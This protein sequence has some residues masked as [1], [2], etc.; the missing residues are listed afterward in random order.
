MFG[1]GLVLPFPLP[2]HG[3]L[4]KPLQEDIRWNG[5]ALRADASKTVPRLIT[6]SGHVMELE[7]LEPGRHF[8]DGITISCHLRIFGIEVSIY[9]RYCKV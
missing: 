3:W 1:S 9:L 5:V 8:Y 7:P 4:K 6:F 2:Q